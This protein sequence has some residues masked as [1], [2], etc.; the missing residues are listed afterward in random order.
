[1]KYSIIAESKMGE[2]TREANEI[3]K[4]EI[5]KYVNDWKGQGEKFIYVTWFR[6]ADGQIGYL[7][8]NGNHEI[9]GK[10]WVE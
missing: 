8:P 6:K 1:M 2:L 10:N 9:T 4:N 7:N 5:K 3:S